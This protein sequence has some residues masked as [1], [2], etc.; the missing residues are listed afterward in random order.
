MPRG[1]FYFTPYSYLLLRGAGAG[2]VC[3]MSLRKLAGKGAGAG[4]GC[5]AD[6]HN[7]FANQRCCSAASQCYTKSPGV[8]FAQCRPSGCIGTCGWECR[9]L[10]PG[11]AADA[12]TEYGVGAQNESQAIAAMKAPLPK[13]A[14]GLPPLGRSERLGN[15]IDSWYFA[16]LNAGAALSH[17]LSLSCGVEVNFA[18][19]LA[20][21]V[22]QVSAT[23]V[24]S[25]QALQAVMRSLSWGLYNYPIIRTL[26]PQLRH[27]LRAAMGQYA[28]AYDPSL[29]RQVYDGGERH[30]VVHYRLGDFVTNSWCIPPAAVATA[31]AA[32]QPSVIEIMD[33]GSHHLDQ[34][35]GY[36]LAPHRVNRTRREHAL[37]LSAQLRVDL[38]AALRAA[39]PSARVTRAAAASIDVDWFRIAHAPLLVTAAGSFAVTAAI[40]SHG[41]HVRT[42]AAENL[43]FPDRAV[44]P[45]EEM[46]RN[47]RT[48]AYDRGAM[49]G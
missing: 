17:L 33:G 23:A 24:Q 13:P 42:P 48:Y 22:G 31:A 6:Y 40:A 15:V 25:Q 16:S 32:L 39:V 19:Y 8:R 47:W 18:R 46:A 20:T 49:R 29:V 2:L 14:G 28:A 36:S 5:T 12:A 30:L 21:R 43:N 34:V 7:C 37:S 38:E 11:A 3:V 4:G 27:D 26:M 44:R 9:L 35:D 1:V 45:E 41:H 10:R